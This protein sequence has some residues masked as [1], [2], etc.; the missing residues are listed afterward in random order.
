MEK[1]VLSLYSGSLF[2]ILTSIAPVLLRT[3]KHKDIAGSFY[4][5]ILWRFYRIAFFLLLLY[6]IMGN[7]WYGLLLLAGL[8]ANV[9]I[10]M[11]LKEYKKILGNIENYDYNDPKRVKFRRLSYLS[12]LVLLI[13]F[14][15]STIILFGEVT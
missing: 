4:G 2:L 13:N 10:S 1:V 11:R 12:T 3:E 6:L 5:R 14:L 7:K 15:I 9:Y 8:S